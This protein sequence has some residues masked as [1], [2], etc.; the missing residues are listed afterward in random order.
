MTDD[1]YAVRFRI[2]QRTPGHTTFTVFMGRKGQGGNCGE[3][4]MRN[5]EFDF[6]A[7]KLLHGVGG[8]MIEP[9]E[10]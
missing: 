9:L 8:E 10:A 6:L 3:L 7:P 2:N 5:D 4:T 1:K